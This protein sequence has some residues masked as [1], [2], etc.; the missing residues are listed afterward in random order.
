V[1]NSSITVSLF[2]VD[3]FGNTSA[4][5]NL[6]LTIQNKLVT[7]SGTAKV[8][9]PSSL[10][11]PNTVWQSV[12]T[13]VTT[14]AAPHLHGTVSYGALNN[15]K[16]ADFWLQVA[17]TTTWGTSIYY[18][19]TDTTTIDCYPTLLLQPESSKSPS[20]Y[21]GGQIDLISPNKNPAGGYATIDWT[22][23]YPQ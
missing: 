16:Y 13:G 10:S 23:T 3:V 11:C 4:A 19:G 22:L 14:Q 20:N 6:N 5:Q 9:W 15:T 17:S 1:F 8:C 2:A 21:S 12:T 7:Q 18:C